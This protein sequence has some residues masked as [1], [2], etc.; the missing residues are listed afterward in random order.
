MA[1][2]ACA[3]ELA[4]AGVEVVL[5]EATG[6]LGGRAHSFQ[7][8]ETGAWIDNCQHV[9]LGCCDEAIG[10]LK[11]IGSLDRIDFRDTVRF[12]AADGRE[13]RLKGSSLPAPLHLSPSLFASDYFSMT[14]KIGLARA[15]SKVPKRCPSRHQS[16]ADYLKSISCP[17]TAIER[18]L[19]PV[20]VS[21][22]NEGLDSASAQCARM[23]ITKALL[24]GRNGYR[25]GVPSAP[26]A[27]VLDAPASR[28]LALR[29]CRVLMATR[30]E[31]AYVSGRRVSSIVLDGGRRM[32][33][34][35]Y[36]AAVPAWSLEKMG[37][38]M[39]VPDWQTWRPIV[40]VHLFMDDVD[41]D[42]DCACVAGEPFGWVFNK[43]ADFGLGFGCL[44]AV[45]GAADGIVD[46]PKDALV[47][48]A[49]RAV[50]KASPKLRGCAPK[51]A[52]IYRARRAT[53]STEARSRPPSE[54]QLSNVFLAGDWTDTG[55]PSTMESAVRSGRAAAKAVLNR[56]GVSSVLRELQ[57]HQ[58]KQGLSQSVSGVDCPCF[59]G[60]TKNCSRKT[61]LTPGLASP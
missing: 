41:P 22:L 19:E 32:C 51:R 47:E 29:G 18:L 43:T 55:W 42:F 20:L 4:D 24:E 60:R 15:L 38:G 36:V 25:L 58:R 31:N 46:M 27:E 44:Q 48:L 52:I 2:L 61:E 49:L 39:L 40:G 54:T 1:G 35:A 59:R 28:Y 11:K 3:C 8:R 53:L 21:A 34:D 26:L 17:R 6:H 56:L 23:V 14:D 7:D 37:L 33:C 5:L 12:V 45:A 50:G 30:V 16:A 10:F 13:L 9:L 57:L